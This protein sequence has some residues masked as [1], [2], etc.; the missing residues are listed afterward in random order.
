MLSVVVFAG[1]LAMAV[2]ALAIDRA[3]LRR[4]HASEVARWQARLDAAT[5]ARIDDLARVTEAVRGLSDTARAIDKL[6][7]I[8]RSDR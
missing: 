4:A 8:A 2:V 6:A 1:P 5:D 3:R 7:D